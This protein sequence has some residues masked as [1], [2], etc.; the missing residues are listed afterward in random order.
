MP[1]LFRQLD[2]ADPKLL[3]ELQPKIYSDSG[4]KA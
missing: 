1:E 4:P 2:E 3:I